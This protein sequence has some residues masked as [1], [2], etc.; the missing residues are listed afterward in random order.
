MADL[1]HL[2]SS[3]LSVD[4]SGDIALTD[5][6]DEVRERV[7]RR[8]MTSVSEYVWHVEYGACLP[9]WVGEVADGARIASLVRSQMLLD[10]AV[11]RVPEPEVTVAV[12]DDGLV[13]LGVT[14]TDAADGSA[15]RVEF[16]IG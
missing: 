11:S 3:D 2:W 8:L 15:R 13:F 1:Q 12:G 10:E 4:A 7:I 9:Q 6:S 14:Y 5:G 16:A